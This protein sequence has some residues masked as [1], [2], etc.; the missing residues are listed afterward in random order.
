MALPVLVQCQPGFRLDARRHL[1]LA[2]PELGWL[3]QQADSTPPAPVTR[4]AMRS[5]QQEMPMQ[6]ANSPASEK[7]KPLE[8]QMDSQVKLRRAP[9]WPE[10]LG[11]LQQVEPMAR[12]LVTRPAMRLPQ[13]EMPMQRA[14][15]LALEEARPQA[16]EKQMDSQ[17][18]LRA[19]LCPVML[20]WLQQVE[21]MGPVTVTRP[22]MRPP[23]QEMSMRRANSLALEEARPQA[24][25]KRPK[26][27]V[28]LR[29]PP[30]P[31][32]L[33]RQESLRDS[34][35]AQAKG[36]LLPQARVCRCWKDPGPCASSPEAPGARRYNRAAHS[37]ARPIFDRCQTP[38]NRPALAGC[39]NRCSHWPHKF[40]GHDR[41]FPI[42]ERDKRQCL[43]RP[44][45]DRDVRFADSEL[46]SSPPMKRRTSQRFRER[47][48]RI[49]S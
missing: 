42:S 11:W 29:T 3:Q 18:K 34:R 17:V 15:S 27:Q 2:R 24:R 28:K 38:H 30:C 35:S 25:E 14:N 43:L 46:R 9:L 36:F 7:P 31:V 12:V 41:P 10:M 21:P 49:L 48:G 44:F 8:K 5:Q 33:P 16:L 20:G 47:E 26:A 19:P 1:R 4:P 13:Q 37:G 32:K 23:Q 6:Q 45:A 40:C 22:A 39:D